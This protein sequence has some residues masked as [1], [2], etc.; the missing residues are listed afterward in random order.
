VLAA[1]DRVTKQTWSRATEP[2]GKTSRVALTATLDALGATSST[3]SPSCSGVLGPFRGRRRH[4]C[5][6]TGSCQR[7]WGELPSLSM[8][9]GRR[10]HADECGQHAAP[11]QPRTVP[12]KCDGNNAIERTSSL[13]NQHLLLGA[14]ERNCQGTRLPCIRTRLPCI[15]VHSL[16]RLCRQFAPSLMQH[17][18][19][20]SQP[21]PVR[22]AWAM[23]F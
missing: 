10:R 18:S 13:T 8:A 5:V 23:A 15:R 16:Q 2:P 1:A 14:R 9:M 19:L 21:H 4:S 6:A 3:L 7:R 11:W 12:S 22:N 17:R 20:D